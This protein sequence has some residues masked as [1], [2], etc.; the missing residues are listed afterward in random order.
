MSNLKELYQLLRADGI[1]IDTIE[2]AESLWLSKYISKTEILSSST[3]NNFITDTK[4]E[5]EDTSKPTDDTPPPPITS[6][7]KQLKQ[8]KRE[9]APLHPVSDSDNKNSLPFRTPLVRKLYKD[10]DLIFA[11]RHFRQKIA[12]LKETKLDEEKIAD[13]IA[14]TDIFRPFYKKSYEKR[15]R[16]LF[17]VDSS[18]SMKIWESMID[19]FVKNVKNYH[20]FKEVMVCYL[21]TDSEEPQ[22]F[23]KKG[24]TSSLNDRWYRHI[25]SNTIAFMFSDMM[26]KSWSSGVLLQQI[27]LWQKH[28]PFAVVQMLPQRLWNGTKLIDASM[29]KM[30]SRKKFALNGQIVSRAEEIL[31]REEEE[32]PELV[33]I[34]LLNFNPSSIEAYGKIMRSLPNNR[35]EGALF[36]AED[37]RGEYQLEKENNELDAEQRLRGFYKYASGEAKELLELLAVVPLSLPIVKLVQ[38]KLL[39]QSTQEH[40]SEVFMSSIVDKEQK[41]DGFYKFSK[42]E[43]EEK[44]VREEL[45][46]KI[47]AKKAFQTIVKLSEVIQKQGGIFDFLAFVVDPASLKRSDEFSEIDREFA[48]I[49]VAL[50]REMG[51]QYRH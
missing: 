16:V 8:K 6:K 40:L 44:G 46:K 42:Y 50:L 29:G 7:V 13:Y 39:P 34:P 21:S 18:E 3:N 17:I 26:S 22:F 33:K 43:D 15:F 31:S 47:G 23:R 35:I 2:L 28:F 49:S 51:E 25:D 1:K 19:E 5:D 41:V 10:N 11:F 37:F 4:E 27:T 9:D 48:R 45:I 38:Q 36:E 14:K 30:S 20:I 12:S 32:L 24:L